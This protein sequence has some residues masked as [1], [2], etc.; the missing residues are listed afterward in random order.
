MTDTRDEIFARPRHTPGF[1]GGSF[2]LTLEQARHILE[3]ANGDRDTAAE[4]ARQLRCQQ[5]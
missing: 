5:P 2:G 3:Q 4:R 1:L